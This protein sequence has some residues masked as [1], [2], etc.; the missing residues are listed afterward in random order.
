[1]P[2][3]NRAAVFRLHANRDVDT[4]AE[5]TFV[6]PTPA[7]ATDRA[8]PESSLLS[9]K[10]DNRMVDAHLVDRARTALRQSPHLARKQLRLE[11]LEGRLVLHGVV[12]SYYQK[13]IAQETLRKVDGV[14]QI[15]NLLQVHWS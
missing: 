11:A 7:G 14:E 8:P 10:G 2:G 13:Q 5:I 12:G 6:A 15:E 4:Y 1:M 9:R 3:S